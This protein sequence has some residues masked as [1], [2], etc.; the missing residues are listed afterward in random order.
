MSGTR[1]ISTTSRRELLSSSPPLQGKASTEIHAILTEILAC[2]L[3]DRAKGL[4]APH[5]LLRVYRYHHDTFRSFYVYETLIAVL[6]IML[7]SVCRTLIRKTLFLPI[8]IMT[9]DVTRFHNNIYVRM[10]YI[11]IPNFKLLLS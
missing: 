1:A 9:V 10:C 7:W 3:R 11:R 2:F 5:V 6:Q 4:S 8:F